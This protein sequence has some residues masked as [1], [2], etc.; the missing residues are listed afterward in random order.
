MWVKRNEHNREI[1]QN[2]QL[3]DFTTHDF[4]KYDGVPSLLLFDEVGLLRKSE[5][6]HLISEL[7][8]HLEPQ[9]MFLLSPTFHHRHLGNF[10]VND[11]HDILTSLMSFQNSQ[12]WTVHLMAEWSR[13]RH[14]TGILVPP[15]SWIHEG[16]H[17][18]GSFCRRSLG[19]LSNSYHRT[20]WL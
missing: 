20:C 19:S 8:A 11:T 4:L 17:C 9:D 2:C 16:P 3:L 18:R 5:K 13:A 15:F 7:E 14:P 10:L 1:H 6:S 12:T